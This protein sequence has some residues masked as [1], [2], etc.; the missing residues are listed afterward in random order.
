MARGPSSSSC[1]ATT[2]MRGGQWRA[3]AER[4]E[5]DA[6]ERAAAAA[7]HVCNVGITSK[8]KGERAGRCSFVA[9]AGCQPRERADSEPSAHRRAVSDL[10]TTAQSNNSFIRNH[11]SRSND[12]QSGC[13][14]RA[15]A[16][17]G[18]VVS[19][20]RESHTRR[21]MMPTAPEKMNPNAA[22]S[23]LRGQTLQPIQKSIPNRIHKL[24]EI[25]PQRAFAAQAAHRV[26]A[27][28]GAVGH[29]RNLTLW[30]LR[31][32]AARHAIFRR[33]S[34]RLA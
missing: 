27:D 4:G 18:S 33:S 19:S 17:R 12:R 11:C 23:P 14:R 15:R 28:E 30:R 3:R 2:T 1:G 29:A 22:W 24:I 20:A 7:V 21:A 6:E 13:A 9:G 34:M 5:L 26:A 31:P 16:L 8:E 25:A 10:R 32:I